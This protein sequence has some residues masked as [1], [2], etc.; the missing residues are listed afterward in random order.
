M[1]GRQSCPRRRRHDA[2]EEPGKRKLAAKRAV[3]DLTARK[4]QEILGGHSQNKSDL[5][6]KFQLQLQEANSLFN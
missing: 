5:G 3:K 6:A 4:R 2:E 1:R